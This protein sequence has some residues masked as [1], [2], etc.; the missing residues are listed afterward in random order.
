MRLQTNLA[1]VGQRR[2]LKA[3]SARAGLKQNAGTFLAF[4][5]FSNWNEWYVNKRRSKDPGFEFRVCGMGH[6]FDVN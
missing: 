3:Y 2:C 4:F 6:V 1:F 5:C